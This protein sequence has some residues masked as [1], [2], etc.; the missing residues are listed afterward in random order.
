[1]PIPIIIPFQ[2]IA[3]IPFGLSLAKDMDMGDNNFSVLAAKDF[4]V[5]PEPD[6][7]WT[8]QYGLSPRQTVHASTL[9]DTNTLAG[10]VVRD[11]MFDKVPSLMTAS[12][13]KLSANGI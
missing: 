11:V 12:F 5:R 10:T 1:V 7:G 9:F 4:P 8:R 3:G 2:I 6:Q 13:D